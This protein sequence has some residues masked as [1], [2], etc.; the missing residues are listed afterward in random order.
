[1]DKN[2]LIKRQLRFLFHLFKYI[3]FCIAITWQVKNVSNKKRNAAIFRIMLIAIL[4]WTM[5]FFSHK[6]CIS[7]FFLNE[8]ADILFQ[9]E[10]ESPQFVK[11]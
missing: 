11:T 2:K 10:R 6:F 1:M 8:K 9:F 4:P 5:L 7:K 3:F